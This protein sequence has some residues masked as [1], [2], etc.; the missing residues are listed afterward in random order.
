MIKCKNFD[1]FKSTHL[2]ESTELERFTFFRKIIDR[3]KLIIS[4]TLFRFNYLKRV[5]FH[6]YYLPMPKIG[7]E[8]LS[9]TIYL[10]I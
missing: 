2:R 6:F 3:D 4:D 1:K 9:Y 5:R 8:Y 7:V 10:S